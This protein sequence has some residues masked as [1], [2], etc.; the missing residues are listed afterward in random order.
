MQTENLEYLDIVLD[1]LYTID[2]AYFNSNSLTYTRPDGR[3]GI[4][5]TSAHAWWENYIKRSGAFSSVGTVAIIDAI[6]NEN[7]IGIGGTIPYMTSTHGTR[8]ASLA[9]VKILD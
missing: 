2:P 4:A 3:I 8:C 9:V 6:R 7:A 5:T 1:A